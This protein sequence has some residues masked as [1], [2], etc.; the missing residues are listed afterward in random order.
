MTP[1]LVMNMA[2]TLGNGALHGK[3]YAA[4]VA[5]IENAARDQQIREKRQAE[6]VKPVL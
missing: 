4:T 1:G 3:T 2:I 5:L 6:A